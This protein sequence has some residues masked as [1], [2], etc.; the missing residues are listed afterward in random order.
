[1]QHF[2]ATTRSVGR[3]LRQSAA[4]PALTLAFQSFQEGPELALFLAHRQLAHF[5]ISE[6]SLTARFDYGMP[7]YIPVRIARETVLLLTSL[8]EALEAAHTPE[9]GS[10][11]AHTPEEGSEAAHTP[12]EGRDAVH[13]P[14]ESGDA[15]GL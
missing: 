1:M 10:E 14:E 8:A 9:E 6:T 5:L 2:R 11:A 13:A 3:R 7:P 15:A 12:E 4:S